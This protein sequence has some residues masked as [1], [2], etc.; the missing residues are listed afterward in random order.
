MYYLVN[1]FLYLHILLTIFFFIHWFINM[2]SSSRNPK[3]PWT[4][5]EETCLVDCLVDLVFAEGW[6]S[7]NRTFWS[8]YLSQ[9]VRMLGERMPRGKL[10][11]T[12]IKSR[13]KLLKRTLQAIA[14]MRWLTCNGFGWNDEVK[15]VILEK[16][17]FDNWVWIRCK[18][19]RMITS[20]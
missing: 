15:C 13:M 18:I 12:V 9:L 17:V 20:L 16:D 2:V 5:A 3:H 1:L 14:E 10:T 8:G 6:R 7:D 4:K 11:T 19:Y